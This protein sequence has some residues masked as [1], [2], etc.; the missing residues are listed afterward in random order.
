MKKSIKNFIDFYE[1]AEKLKTTTRHSWLSNPKR[2]ESTAE[3]S[4]MLGLMAMIL[5]DEIRPKVNLLKVLKMVIIHDLAEAITGDIPSH[6][7]SMRNIKANKKRAEKKAIKS[8]VK[9]LPKEKGNEIF[10]LWK[11]M[12][13]N[14]TQEAHFSHSLDKIEAILQHNV[15]SISTWRQG[16]FFINPY[17]KDYFFDFDNFMRTFKDIVDN[18]TMEKIIK[19]KKTHKVEAKHMERYKKNNK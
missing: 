12:E 7:V 14:K 9:K 16:D 2:Q 17:Y 10:S 13:E 1:K 8:I 6:E 19:A 5:A 15:A 4:W 18:Q 3:H 11:E